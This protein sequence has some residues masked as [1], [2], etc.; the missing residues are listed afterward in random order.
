MTFIQDDPDITIHLT[1]GANRTSPT[2][3]PRIE[4]TEGRRTLG[5]CLAPNGHDTTEHAFHLKEAITL[6]S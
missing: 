3:V 4:N 2:P 1:Q 5:V 6:R